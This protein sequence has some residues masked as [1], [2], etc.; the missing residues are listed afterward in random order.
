[1]RESAKIRA[2]VELLIG[3][4]LTFANIVTPVGR[5]AL[6]TLCQKVISVLLESSKNNK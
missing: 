4:T 2:V 3:Q 5:M 1:M 6:S